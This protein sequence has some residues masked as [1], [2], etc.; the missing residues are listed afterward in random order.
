MPAFYRYIILWK[1]PSMQQQ[2]L[3]LFFL[4]FEP[5][6]ELRSN[7][8]FSFD[9]FCF[10]R[11]FFFV[12]AHCFCGIK[13]F[14]SRLYFIPLISLLFSFSCI[15]LLCAVRVFYTCI[16]ECFPYPYLR[17]FLLFFCCYVVSQHHDLFSFVSW[18]VYFLVI[19]KWLMVRII[20]NV[21]I[22]WFFLH[23]FVWVFGCCCCR[24]F[25]HKH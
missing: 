15:F 3:L 12:P 17:Y 7:K 21:H 19:G 24:R 10:I 25:V 4:F 2:I 22:K 20:A 6:P 16:S 14:N 11:W 5:L 13:V 23:K 1:R 18:F 8:F 9:I